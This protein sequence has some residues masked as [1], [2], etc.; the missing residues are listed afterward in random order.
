MKKL[1]KSE[2]A[3]FEMIVKKNMR[4]GYFAALSILG[5]HDDAVEISQLA[6]VKAY[7]NFKNFDR[8]K[9][10][11]TWYYTILRNLCF[12]FIRDHKKFVAI[13]SVLEMESPSREADPQRLAEDKQ[14]EE[15]IN[16]ALN[17]LNPEDREIIILREFQN[18]SY[19]EISDML[20]IPEGTVMSRLYYAR[21]KLAQKLEGIEL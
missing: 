11:F 5:S 13:D 17:E 20:Q 16:Q 14:K 7:K 8:N 12:N 21:K 1:T 2:K 9:N 15:L 10:F 3:E 6:F 4:R 18:Y 19:K